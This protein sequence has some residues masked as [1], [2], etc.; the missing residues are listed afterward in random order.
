MAMIQLFLSLSQLGLRNVP[1]IQLS[2]A[3]LSPAQPADRLLDE[4]RQDLRQVIFVLL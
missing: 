4:S 1:V 2:P 3:N